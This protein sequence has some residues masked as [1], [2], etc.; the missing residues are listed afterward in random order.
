MA[1]I[2]A[3]QANVIP[4][5]VNRRRQG[6]LGGLLVTAIGGSL[7]V[8]ALVGEHRTAFLFLAL[9]AAFAVAYIQGRQPYV[10][11]V[12]TCTLLAFGVGMLLAYAM[13]AQASGATF[14]A[15]V[16]MGPVAVFI[17]RP[18]RRWPLIITAVLG[19]LAV[20]EM[21]GVRAVPA[22]IEPLLVPATLVAV[23]LY[24]IFAPRRS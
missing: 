20:A 18:A 2:T 15:S 19:G 13:P 1:A 12:P 6:S 24:L 10:Y 23:G 21:L 11:L 7:F 8:S 3:T 5:V 4:Q 22:A 17:I 9:G 14:L 16:A